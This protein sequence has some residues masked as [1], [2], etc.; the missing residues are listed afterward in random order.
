[1]LPSTLSIPLP[2][3]GAVAAAGLADAAR[4]E[5][6]VDVSEHVLRALRVVLDAARVQ[7][8]GGFRRAPHFRRGDDAFR[9]DAGDFLRHLGCVAL[10]QLAHFVEVVRVFGDEFFVD[11]PA[12][13]HHMQDAVRERAV[14]SR[15]HG[16]E[17]IRRAPD[18]RDARV[19]DDDFRARI[20]RPPDVV[21][22]DRE[23]L[24]EVRAGEDDDLGEGDVAPR[25][26]GA[27]HA[28]RHAI[29]RARGDHAEAAVV[30]D[31]RGLERDARELAVEV[32]LLVGH[33]RA[34]EKG[35]RIFSMLRLNLFDLRCGRVQ[36]LVPAR[37][38]KAV[39]AANERREQAVGVIVLHVTLH[40]FRA[41]LALVDG[42]FFPRLEPDDL[43]VFD[44]EL[45]AALHAA[46]AAVRLHEL[47]RLAVVPATRGRVRQ[48]GAVH[49]DV[50]F[51]G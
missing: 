11:P 37:G 22:E 4:G 30:I 50:F 38:A 34:A 45:D 51:F 32:S 19:D 35:E 42:E 24:R 20:A 28:E 9:R 31:V 16:Q 3:D 27:I 41:E 29:R 5:H 18:R 21:G 46:K 10:H 6:E 40:A 43:V 49:L 2:G 26:R 36:R 48:R 14:P 44:L 7:Q 13:D 15:T 33:R 17:E 1:M 39:G 25:I 47:V 23:A 12:L 8:H